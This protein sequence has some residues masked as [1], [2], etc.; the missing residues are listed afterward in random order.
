MHSWAALGHTSSLASPELNELQVIHA[1]G[2]SFLFLVGQAEA[3]GQPLELGC[4]ACLWL[5]TGMDSV[6]D[7]RQ[8]LLCVLEASKEIGHLGFSQSLRSP[9]P[10]LAHPMGWSLDWWLSGWPGVPGK[11]GQHRACFI[12]IFLCC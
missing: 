3:E 9:I 8:H 4:P 5:T 10:L 6:R 12:A 7:V 1:S 2:P 11:A